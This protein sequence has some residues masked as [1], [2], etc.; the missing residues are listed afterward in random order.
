MHVKD[1]RDSE[2]WRYDENKWYSVFLSVIYNFG[3]YWQIMGG[4]D[5]IFQF[6]KIK[7]DTK[8][9]KQYHNLKGE[10]NLTALE[11]VYLQDYFSLI[12]QNCTFTIRQLTKHWIFFQC[13]F[14]I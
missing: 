10:L 1:N 5:V 2:R 13:V 6:K 14:D 8:H 4:S 9:K 3:D 7:A 12:V 11:N